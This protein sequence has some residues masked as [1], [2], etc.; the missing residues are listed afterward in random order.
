MGEQEAHLAVADLAAEFPHDQ[1]FQVGLVVDHEN[2]RRDSVGRWRTVGHRGK[3]S[4]PPRE[5][6]CAISLAGGANV[7]GWRGRVTGNSVK[8][9]SWGSGSIVPPCCFPTMS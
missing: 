1:S 6:L 5:S 4:C 2:Q 3:A 8:G 9:P 7:A